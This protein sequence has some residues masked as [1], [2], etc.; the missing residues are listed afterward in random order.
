MNQD[1]YIIRIYRRDRQNPRMLVGTVERIGETLKMGFTDFE[2]LRG[3]LCVPRG[4][5]SRRP[6]DGPV[7]GQE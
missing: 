5:P 3:I 1:N 4:K 2:E 6:E 7:E